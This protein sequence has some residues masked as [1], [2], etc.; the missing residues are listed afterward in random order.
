MS[1]TGPEDKANVEIDRLLTAAG[2][3]VC[4]YGSHGISKPFVIREFPLKKGHG[5]VIIFN[6]P[7]P[8][9]KASYVPKS[10][11]LGN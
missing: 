7:C 10:F 3:H 4:D 1:P 5:A 2:W 9:N 11:T 6:V 8:L